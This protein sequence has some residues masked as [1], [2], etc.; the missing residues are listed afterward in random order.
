MPSKLSTT[1]SKMNLIPNQTNAKLVSEF[2]HYMQFKNSSER[3]QNNN[4][5]VLMAFAHYLGAH[6]SFYNIEQKE[7][8]LAFL[9][10]KKRSIEQ[11]PDQRWITTW[12]HNLTRIKQFFRWVANPHDVPESEWKTPVFAQI[13]E[14]KTI[15][16]SPYTENQIWERENFRGN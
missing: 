8:I 10:T 16:K 4:L 9:D 14:K 3:H 12:N 2:Y 11:D 6:V 5:Q 1:V 15:R 13:K 7:K